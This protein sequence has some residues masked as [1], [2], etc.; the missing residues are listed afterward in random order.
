MGCLAIVDIDHGGTVAHVNLVVADEEV[1][2]GGVGQIDGILHRDDRVDGVVGNVET[3]RIA[4]VDA[5]EVLRVA[6]SDLFDVVVGDNAVGIVQADTSIASGYIAIVH[7]DLISFVVAA[8]IVDTHVAA[9]DRTIT[10]GDGIQ[11][12]G[13]GGRRA[14]HRATVEIVRV[15]IAGFD[16]TV[17]EQDVTAARAAHDHT[18]RD[19]CVVALD[20]Q[21]PEDEVLDVL[22]RHGT[23]DVGTGIDIIVHEDDA[24]GIITLEG[25]RVHGRLSDV[26]LREVEAGVGARAQVEH[27]RTAE[28]AIVERHLDSSQIREVGIR[29]AHGIVALQQAVAGVRRNP[30][31]VVLVVTVHLAV[32]GG[33]VNRDIV[34][35]VGR[36]EGTECL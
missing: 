29:A 7:H 13:R 5:G 8:D 34:V 23:E 22:E 33:H 36:R 24:V 32:T 27:G 21:V 3:C 30:D 9:G 31:G 35:P 28:S 12:R 18:S 11:H 15:G 16:D 6:G 4:G 19:G 25:D 26:V 14:D 1:L 20:G 17:V 10:E 2:E